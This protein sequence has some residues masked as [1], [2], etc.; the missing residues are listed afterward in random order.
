MNSN[1]RRNLIILALTAFFSTAGY[2]VAS[3]LFYKTGYP[4]DDAWIYQT[5]ARNLSQFGEWSFIPGEASGGSTGPLWVVFLTTGYFLGIDHHIWTFILGGFTLFGLGAVGIYAFTLLR[6]ELKKWTLLA[7]LILVLEWH[8]VWAAASGM[9]TLL[10]AL[11]TTCTLVV[12]FRETL[13]QKEWLFVGFLVGLSVWIRP[14]GITLLG[15]V[16]FSLLLGKDRTLAEKV[17]SGLWVLIGF[18]IPFGLYLLFNQI[19]SGT[20]WPNTFYAKQAEYA[21]LRSAPYLERIFQQFILPLTGIGIVLLF[22]FVNTIYTAIAERKWSVLASVFWFIGFLGIYAWRLPATYQYGRYIIPA[23]PVFFILGT[24][25]MSAWINQHLQDEQMIL[26][27]LS[28][29]WLISSISVLA[30]FWFLGA[31]AYAE[32]VAVIESEMVVTANWIQENTP[33]DAVIAAHDIGALGYFSQRKIVDLAGL[34]SPDVIPFIRDETL[35][36]NYLNHQKADYLMTFPEWYDQLD[37][38]A[39]FLYQTQGIF[40]PRLGGENMA[41][42]QWIIPSAE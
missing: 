34:I 8:L 27:V 11:T 7:G 37:E 41:V 1:K 15:P 39:I 4:L 14:D 20:V 12:L 2:M 18:A 42:Y 38:S 9:E 26:R 29:V 21:E 17:K 24:A 23:M 3:Y 13:T 6:P 10:A 30:A 31:K 22:G 32:G 35:L 25:G 40:S 5:Y 16:G 28:K 36:I 33:P 19:T